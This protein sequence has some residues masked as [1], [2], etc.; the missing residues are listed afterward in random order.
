MAQGK[1]EVELRTDDSVACW[2]LECCVVSYEWLCGSVNT[3][4]P[5]QVVVVD[6]FPEKEKD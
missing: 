2:Q 3:N 5:G 6:T 4:G 1:Q